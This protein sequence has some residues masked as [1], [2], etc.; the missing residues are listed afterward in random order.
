MT[1]SPP[2]RT[3]KWLLAVLVSVAVFIALLDTT[4]VDIVLPKM[5]AAMETDIYGIQ[6][7]VITYFLGAAI[8]MTAVGW[9]A[10]VVGHRNTYCFGIVLF[11][12][13]SALAGFA[14]TLEMM[15][16]ARFF[17]GI[18]EGIMMPVGLLILYETFPPEERGL[19]MGVYGISASFA[20]ALGPTLGG[21]LT[22]YLNWR[23]VFFINIPVGI[24]DVALIWWLMDNARAVEKPPRFDLVGFLLAATALSA[25]IVLLG[26]GQEHGWLHSDFILTLTIVFIAFGIAAVVWM[27][28]SANPLFPRRIMKHQPFRLSIWA[29]MLFSIT[30]Y[31]FFFLLPIYLQQVHG[32]TTFQSGLILLPGALFAGLATLLSGI[33]SDRINPKVVAAVCLA[34]AAIASWIFHTDPDTPREVIYCDYILWGFFIGGTFAPVTLLALGTLEERDVANGSTLVN[35]SRLVAGSIGTSYAT[36][37]LSMKKDTFFEALSGNLTWGSA[38]LTDILSRLNT[39]REGAAG[40]FDPDTWTRL[41][42]QA[43]QILLLRAAGFAFEAVYQYLAL[44]PLAALICVALVRLADRR[45]IKTALH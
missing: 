3:N 1:Q 4:I 27:S 36:S 16:F 32:Y 42:F 39:Y 15:L 28:L 34:G 26:K 43:K 5:M 2:G 18:A 14:T 29:M 7:V 12:A 38:V 17:Q 8:A 40:A 10:D 13:M 24:T 41:I 37:V 45:A 22:E 44:F 33:L 25:L 30:A 19:A 21:L 9:T 35:V 11:V 20:P 23:W 31:G 6:W